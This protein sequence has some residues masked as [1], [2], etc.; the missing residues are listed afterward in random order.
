MKIRH[1]L[2]AAVIAFAP[3]TVIAA[4]VVFV[5]QSA[6]E[7]HEVYFSAASLSEWGEDHL[8]SEI[9]ETGDSLTLSNVSAGKWDVLIIDEDGDECVLEDVYISSSDRWVITDDVDGHPAA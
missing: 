5:N 9:L 1:V 6:W 8:G 4:K 2:A 7:I 3:T